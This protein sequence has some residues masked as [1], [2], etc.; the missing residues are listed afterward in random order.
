LIQSL[1]F[2]NFRNYP[3]FHLEVTGRIV[4]IVGDNAVGKT[5]IIE[6]IQLLS[7]LCSFRNPR[8]EEVVCRKA[9]AFGPLISTTP[10]QQTRIALSFEQEGRGLE[11]EMRIEANR[12]HYLVNGKVKATGDLYGLLPA[13]IFTPDDLALVKGPAEARRTLLD[14]LG[15]QLSRTYAA[16]RHD[17]TK[18][19]KQKN[20]LLKNDYLDPAVLAS[21]NQNL[22]SLG[23]LLF[24][25]RTR[26]YR[27]FAEKAAAA[28]ARI[29]P[30]ERLTM[31]Y[32]P[33]FGQV[34]PHSEPTKEEVET[35]IW[36]ALLQRKEEEVRRAKS[37]VGP[38]RDEV[39]FLLDG[40]DARTYGSQGQQRTIALACKVTE[41]ELL[42]EIGGSEPVLLLDDVMSEL[43]E[44]RRA[45][46]LAII[47][48][49]AQTFITTT[50]LG[51]FSE[52]LIARAQ[53]VQLP[54]APPSSQ[55][56]NKEVD[57]GNVPCQLPPQEGGGADYV[58]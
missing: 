55:L 48:E 3:A 26:L 31:A 34:A 15:S 33:S 12:R 14:T 8:W 40:N 25:H 4:I 57:K 41:V 7:M 10:P 43:D 29:S 24:V 49:T 16:I 44:Q 54:S 52:E 19:V 46:L 30:N 37:L 56:A 39:Q 2:W 13:V 18:V 22:A 50:N 58:L 20:Q 53:V 23:A 6:G 11:H 9:P 5:N 17:Y 32:Q 51:Y 47:D 21:W 28:Y 45:A 27:R 35:L 36:D 38:H 1:D 42:R